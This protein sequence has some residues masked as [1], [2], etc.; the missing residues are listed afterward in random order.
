MAGKGRDQGNGDDG[1]VAFLS[2]QNVL[3]HAG[4]W[5]AILDSRVIAAGPSLLE[6]HK[7]ASAQA[8]GRKPYYYPVPKATRT[9]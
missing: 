4:E 6:V 9:Y 8:K 2:N 7:K 3:R 1:V 5:V